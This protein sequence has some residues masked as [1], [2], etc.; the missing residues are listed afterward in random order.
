MGHINHRIVLS[1]A[2]RKLRPYQFSAF[3]RQASESE[4]IF[5]FFVSLAFIPWQPGFDPGNR[6]SRC[7][8]VIRTPAWPRR[9]Q[10]G[11]VSAFS[12]WE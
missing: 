2:R 12:R 10:T 11:S 8:I 9:A 5:T 4:T 7:W 3:E 1:E 6:T